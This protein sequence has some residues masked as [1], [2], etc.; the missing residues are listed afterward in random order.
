MNDKKTK[1]SITILWGTKGNIRTKKTY[2]FDSIN[3]LNMFMK[4]VDEANG[5]LEYEAINQVAKIEKVA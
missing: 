4:G 3:D 5:W 1:H 2:S